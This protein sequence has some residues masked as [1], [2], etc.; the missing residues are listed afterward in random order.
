MKVVC[1]A[2][3]GFDDI[4]WVPTVTDTKAKFVV[5]NGS[6]KTQ[7]IISSIS[8]LY[9][10]VNCEASEP[11]GILRIGPLRKS[12]APQIVDEIDMHACGRIGT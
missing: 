2:G 12:C 11:V 1:Y 6:K 8:R 4:Y 10:Q 9:T 7:G 5:R 3:L